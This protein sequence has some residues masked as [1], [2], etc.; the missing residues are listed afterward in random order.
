MAEFL[1]LNGIAVPVLVDGARFEPQRLQDSDRAENMALIEDLRATK[2]RWQWDVKHQLRANGF[3]Y[4]GLVHGEGQYWSFDTD[5][6]GSRGTP[7]TSA[8]G[9]VFSAGSAW[10]GAGKVSQ[11]AGGG[12]NIVFTPLRAGSTDGWTVMVARKVGGAAWQH[13]IVTSGGAVYTDGVLTGTAA[14]LAVNTANGTVTLTSDAASTTL[15][16]ELVVLPYPMP[17]TWPAQAY[18]FQNP[19]G[20][21]TQWSKLR[22]LK[23]Q[24]ECLPEG[25]TKTVHGQVKDEKIQPATISG[26]YEQGTRALS[27]EFQEV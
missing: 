8:T 14:W 21:A 18:A 25:G 26:T 13:F 19:A 15:L 10:L 4:R 3:A 12:N 6:Y 9:S 24:G 16:D 7:P 20:T 22:Q 5:L 17:S 23:L 2:G 11:T 1:T 27:I